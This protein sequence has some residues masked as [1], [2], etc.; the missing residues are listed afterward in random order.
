MP[1]L[2]DLEADETDLFPPPDEE[3]SGTLARNAEV[4]TRMDEGGHSVPV[5]RL[6][7]EDCGPLHIAAIAEQPFPANAYPQAEAAAKRLKKGMRLRV[8]FSLPEQRV[9]LPNVKHISQEQPHA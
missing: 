7:L 2:F 5:L 6:E 9:F 1:S 3:Y 4:R 8:A